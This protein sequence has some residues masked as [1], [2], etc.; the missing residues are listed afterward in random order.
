MHMPI[1]KR[2]LM[3]KISKQQT[4]LLYQC[5]SLLFIFHHYESDLDFRFKQSTTD[6]RYDLSPSSCDK[7]KWFPERGLLTPFVVG[8]FVP[9][10][11]AL[12]SST[13]GPASLRGVRDTSLTVPLGRECGSNLPLTGTLAGMFRGNEVE[14]FMEVAVAPS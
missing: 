14:V 4:D 6:T 8:A 5:S 7:L 11:P 10:H 13:N 2:Q 9:L 1:F 3:I 12:P